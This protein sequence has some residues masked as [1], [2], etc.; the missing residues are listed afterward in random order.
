MG[1]WQPKFEISEQLR[2]HAEKIR[3][4]VFDVD[5]VL[6]DG[7]IT[8][9]DQGAESKSFNTQDGHGIKL[10]QKVGIKTGIISAR[11]SGAVQHRVTDLGINHY[12]F[13]QHDKVAALDEVLQKES[14]NLEQCVY[15][16]DDW[17]DIPVMLK[18]GLA[19]AV[20]NAHPVVQHIAHWTTPNKGGDGAARCVCDL[21]LDAQGLYDDEIASMMTLNG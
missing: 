8:F 17:V 3:L 11:Q 6:T 12:H 5:G 15:V 13:G 1:I 16:G 4:V 10:L 20:A 18:V 19:I 21:I 2:A 7:T 9:D 14:L